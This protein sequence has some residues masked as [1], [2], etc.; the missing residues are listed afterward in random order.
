MRTPARS[1]RPRSPTARSLAD[2]AHADAVEETIAAL[3]R[4]ELRVATPPP[5][6]RAAS[7][8]RTP[9]SKQ[10]ILLYFAVRKMERIEVGPFEFH[11]KIPLKHGLDGRACASCRRASCATARSSSRASS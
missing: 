5:E 2:P 1:S 4:G 11:D 10:A 3:D 8:R 6:P 9:G 7:G